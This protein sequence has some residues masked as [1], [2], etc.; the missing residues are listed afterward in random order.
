MPDEVKAAANP[1]PAEKEENEEVQENEE[2]NSLLDEAGKE[3][4]SKSILDKAGE[5]DKK[6]QIA[7]E[8]ELLKKEEKYLSTEE[9]IKRKEILKR[10]EEEK[11]SEEAKKVPEKYEVKLP[12][13]MALDEKLLEKVSPIAKKY[14]LTKE[15]F[16]ELA[17]V[18][19]EHQKTIGEQYDKSM[20]ENFDKFVEEQKKETIK[21]LGANV[22]EKLRFVAKIRDYAFSPQTIEVFNASGLAN[23]K[24]FIN[25]LIKLGQTISEGKVVDG[26]SAIPGSGKS[27]AERFYPKS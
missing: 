14:G 6:K 21:E 3:D 16:Q 4:D 20:K 2:G 17:D 7:E 19:A 11:K 1:N 18:Y 26:K 5:E 22:Q 23:N 27:P 12:E 24:Y 8:D 13:G 25:D 15:A 9:Q 10:R